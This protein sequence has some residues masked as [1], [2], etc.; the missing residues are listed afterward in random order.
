MLRG[1]TRRF[2]NDERGG[3]T[4]MG[5]LW[6]ML[7]VGITGLAVDITDGLRSQTMLQATADASA[8]AA[9]IDLPDEEIAVATAI[10]YSVTNMA[11]DDY[12]T[13][14]IEGDVDIG[15]WDAAT[16]IFSLGGLVP[17]AVRVRTRRSFENEN[18]VPVN[19]LRIIGLM[20][21]NV[22]TYAIAQRFIPDCLLNDG[23]VARGEI[24]IAGNNDFEGICL[25][26]QDHVEVQNHNTWD[27]DVS[28]SMPDMNDFEVA[29]VKFNPGAMEALREDI[30]DP[31]MVNDISNIVE[32][33][34]NP[35]LD[36]G[37]PLTDIVPDFVIGTTDIVTANIITG[38]D[39]FDFTK[40][41]VASV[42]DAGP[43]V[44]IDLTCKSDNK[45]VD[46]PSGI[47]LTDLV[48]ISSCNINVGKSATLSDVTLAATG[49]NGKVTTANIH[50]S[51]NVV[52][53]KDDDCAPGG[54]VQVFTTASV[55]SAAKLSLNGVQMVAAGN[56]QI[57]AKTDGI[58]GISMQTGGKIKLA[59]NG[60]FG[61]CRAG[62]PRLFT[63]NYYRLVY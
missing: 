14:L 22:T 9:A 40:Y 50:F 13:V 53:G 19:F 16:H 29:Q 3:G 52:L 8:L 23:L 54:G 56:V 48:I 21:W 11:T 32:T 6:F 31:R 38:D 28:I 12:G 36:A 63:V 20:N 44:I 35:A 51:S 25:H 33:L 57:A 15:N 49:G 27:S 55:S 4:V 17:D 34:Q 10:A 18:A 62:T 45:T 61:G 39:K 5:L 59:S 1:Y 42:D 46:I 24:D 7:L 60:T 2:L 58:N 47:I 30:L 43:G 26:S 41:A 37:D